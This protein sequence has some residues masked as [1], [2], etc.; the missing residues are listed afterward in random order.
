MVDY[1]AETED[2]LSRSLGRKVG[3]EQKRRGGKIVLEFYDSDD[4]EA[5]IANLSRMGRTWEDLIN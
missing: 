5:L 4:R 3:I 1:I 2:Q